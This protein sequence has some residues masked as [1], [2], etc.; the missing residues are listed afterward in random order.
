MRAGRAFSIGAAAALLAFLAQ[1][2]G[3]PRSLTTGGGT[4]GAS[5]AGAS[6]STSGGAAGGTAGVAGVSGPSG[7]AV[8]D[9]GAV[10]AGGADGGPTPDAGMADAGPGDAGAPDAGPVLGPPLSAGGWTFYGTGQGLSATITD[11]SA[12]EAGNVYVAGGDAVYAKTRGA[13]G[14]S[15]FGAE[16]GLTT[17]C[18]EAETQL[19][20]VISVAGGGAGQAFIGLQGIGTDDDNDPMWEQT[21]GG[22]DELSFDG[23]RLRKARHVLIA[24]PPGAV[25]EN[26]YTMKYGRR[27]GRQLFRVVFNHA[28]GLNYGDLWMGGTHVGFSVLFGDSALEGWQDWPNQYPDSMGVWEHDHPAIETEAGAIETGDY[29]AIAIDPI[30]GDPW[31]ASEYR[32]ASK[33]GYGSGPG[34]MWNPLWPA[35]NPSDPNHSYLDVWP[36]CVGSSDPNCEYDIDNPAWKDDTESMTFCAD[37]TQYFGS[38]TLGIAVRQT[39]GQISYIDLPS[40]YG[41]DVYALACDPSD[42]SVWVGLGWGGIARLHPDGSFSFMPTNLNAPAFAQQPVR[43]IQI[44]RWANPRIVYFAQMQDAKTLAAGGVTAYSGP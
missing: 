32:A 10:D 25:P 22:V 31:A 15:R 7:G 28:P 14:F 3:V 39:N 17:N 13:Q 16:V 43:S 11:V 4:G 1:G 33:K 41:D 37:G 24:S 12:D 8:L 23:T 40:G 30:S 18:D 34:Q 19:C 21:S 2:C 42:Q 6:E 26:A 20:P 9:A 38:S 44:D 27:K 36:D 5:G 29:Y 35:Y